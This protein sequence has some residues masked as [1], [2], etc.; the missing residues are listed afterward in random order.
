MGLIT[1]PGLGAG[2]VDQSTITD[3]L[4][5]LRA[6]YPNFGGVMG[7]E[8]FNSLP[9]DEA[10]P[11]QW[12]STMAR[13]IRT[14]LPPAQTVDAGRGVERPGIGGNVQMPMAPQPFPPEHVQTLMNL[15]FSS[16]QAQMALN[17]TGGN[18]EYAAGLLF[19]D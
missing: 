8:Y 19:E 10:Q 17:R 5:V 9:G 2:Y 18:V 13:T 4:R 12:A 1:N 11:W 14:A 16:Q 15:G 3:V 7:W 6:K